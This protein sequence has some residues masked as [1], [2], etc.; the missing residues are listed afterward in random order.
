MRRALGYTLVRSEKLLAQFLTYLEAQGEDHL[1]TKTA[2]AWAMLPAG[3]DRSWM[4][5][6]LSVVRRFATHLCGIEPATEVPPCDLLPGRSC[7]ATPYLYSQEDVIALMT[8]TAALRTPHREA[9]YRTLIG[10]LAVT[11][12]RVGE[13]IG[14][15]RGDFDAVGGGL[16]IR[17]GK[18]GK[19][20][21]L[22]LHPSTVAAL[23]NYL[24]RRDQPRRPPNTPAL[25]VSPAGTRL[26]YVNVQNTF[27]KLVCRVGIA[28][29]SAGCRPRL[30][31]LR[32]AFAVRTLL[33]AYRDGRRPGAPACPAVDLSRSRRSGQDVLVS[34]GGSG[35]AATGR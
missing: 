17:R 21:E 10:L 23:G 31:D 28:P 11:G 5:A 29:R 12:M 27:Q 14:L 22:A 34:L 7:R 25:F 30:H 3:A 4:S 2:L 9:T 1:T 15:D 24:R 35:I 20:H 8:A 18:S 32:H 26:L 33:D 16:T 19:S 6:R 13:A